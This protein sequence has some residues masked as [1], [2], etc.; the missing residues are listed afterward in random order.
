MRALEELKW[1]LGIRVIR[2]RDAR[3]LWLC[4]DLYIVKIAAKFHLDAESTSTAQKSP[5][6]T[7]ELLLNKAQATTQQI[8]AYQQRVGSLSFAA[9]ISRPDI[10]HTVS[11]LSQFLRNPSTAHIS[12]LIRA[13]SYLYKTRNYAIEYSGSFDNKLFLCASN[14]AFA[15][16]SVTRRSSDGYLV[17]LYGGAID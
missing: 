14:A 3:K 12:A 2:N 13:I 11:K 4:Q 7:T 15:D 10:L 5:L 17:Q 1:F 9:V 8:F 16:N 6:S